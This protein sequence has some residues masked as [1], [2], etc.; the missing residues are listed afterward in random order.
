MNPSKKL[1]LLVLLGP[2]LFAGE[3]FSQ[4]GAPTAHTI[5]MTAIE[6]KGST[7]VEKLAPPP[8]N[9]KDLSKGYEFKPPGQADKSDP[10][11]WEVSSYRF[12]PGFITVRQ[13][14][15]VN[16]TVFVVNGDE[17]DVAVHDPGGSEVVPR[18]KWNR[19]REYKVSFVAKKVGSY[20]LTCSMHA[21]TMAAT[22]L[23]LPR[24]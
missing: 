19:G 23:V 11:K 6:L 13:G 16:L 5:F 15:T 8:V 17:H 12:S 1:S 18:T 4:A 14:D 21:P 9:P 3:A 20:Q 7:T 10:K 24:K 2:L 22:I